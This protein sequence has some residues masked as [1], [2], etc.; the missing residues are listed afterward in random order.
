M[1]RSI[2]YVIILCI[3]FLGFILIY[4]SDFYLNEV[5]QINF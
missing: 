1:K 5:P 4:V 2:V 3:L